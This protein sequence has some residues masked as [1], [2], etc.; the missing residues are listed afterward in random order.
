V[1]LPLPAGWWKG[2][3]LV[4]AFFQPPVGLLLGL[5]YWRAPEPGVGR[6]ARICLVLAALGLLLTGGQ[7]AFRAGLESGERFIQPY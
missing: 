4:L 6:F 1:L 3:A 5:L 2:L 7:D